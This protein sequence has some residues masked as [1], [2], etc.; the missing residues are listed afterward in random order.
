MT[1]AGRPAGGPRLLVLGDSLA[2]HGPA[3]PLPADDARLWPNVAAAAL[4]GVA[5]L[6]AGIGWT[7]R[8][9]WWALTRDPRVWALLPAVDVLV[10]AVGSMDTLPSPLPTALREGI[11]YLRPDPLRRWA[12]RGYVAA[13]PHLARLLRGRP[14]AL[15]PALTVRYL[16]RCWR[17]VRALRPD[18]P[19]VGVVPSVHRSA[20]Y[21]YVHTGHAPAVAAVRAWSHRRDVP[22]LDLPTL[23]RP[24]L[25]G[26]DANPD[27]MHWGWAAHRRVGD[28]L[29]ETITHLP[30]RR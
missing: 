24:H 29:A 5:D 4:G 18:L 1:G 17:A 10:L 26:A 14:V 7:A 19:V 22:L 6:V 20:A 25:A 13:Q 2:F 21:A 11:R 16:D 28:A 23:V 15:P 3:G 27:G 12:R 30:P 9:V 8:D